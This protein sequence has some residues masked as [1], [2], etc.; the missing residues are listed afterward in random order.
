MIFDIVHSAYRIP[1]GSN[2]SFTQY[3]KSGGTYLISNGWGPSGRGPIELHRGRVELAKANGVADAAEE[4]LGS[5]LA[6]IGSTWIA[7]SDH[8]NTLVDGSP[9]RA[10]F[11]H[12][13][14]GIAGFYDAPYVD[15]PLNISRLRQLVPTGNAAPPRSN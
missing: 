5:S 3:L 9:A 6:V 11:M 15:L 8:M 2:Q 4:A 7:E 1:T 10:A 13:R 14:V 12:H